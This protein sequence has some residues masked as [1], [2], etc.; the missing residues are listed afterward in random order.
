MLSAASPRTFYGHSRMCV[1]LR[2]LVIVVAI[3]VV[4]EVG[5]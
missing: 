3:V 4:V 2:A 1:L 5:A